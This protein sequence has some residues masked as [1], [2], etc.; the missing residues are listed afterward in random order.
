MSLF[1]GMGY[2]INPKGGLTG[3]TMKGMRLAPGGGYIAPVVRVPQ[4]TQEEDAYSRLKDSVGIISG[5]IFP[6]DCV[7]KCTF[8]YLPA[9]TTIADACTSAALPGKGPYLVTGFPII[10]ADKFADSFNTNGTN[11]QPWFYTGGGEINGAED[12]KEWTGSITLYRFF[13]ISDRVGIAT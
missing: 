7:L 11:A 2:I 9:G 13:N 4:V 12:G 1:Y 8:A 6:D 3:Y 10:Q 5:L